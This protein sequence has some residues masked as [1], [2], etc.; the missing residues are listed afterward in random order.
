MS[1]AALTKTAMIGR[2]EHPEEL[3]SLNDPATSATPATPAAPAKKEKAQSISESSEEEHFLDANIDPALLQNPLE[4]RKKGLPWSTLIP[5]GVLIAV[6]IHGA[7]FIPEGSGLSWINWIIGIGM[8]VWLIPPGWEHCEIELS[9]RNRNHDL[10]THHLTLHVSIGVVLAGV[11]VTVLPDRLVRRE[12]FQ[13][14]LVVLV[15]SALVVV[16]KH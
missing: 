7:F 3:I 6:I 14:F 13:P 1:L 11:V 9:V 4:P 5:I 8:F 12:F 16:D 15:Q 2:T 10:P